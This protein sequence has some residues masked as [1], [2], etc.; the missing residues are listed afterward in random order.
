[1]D[2][3]FLNIKQYLLVFGLLALIVL[4]AG[5][6]GGGDDAEAQLS[7]ATYIKRA[8]RIC[9]ETKEKTQQGFVTYARQNYVPESGA[10]LNAKV[11]DFVVKVFTPTYEQQLDQLEALNGPS[12]DREKTTKILAAM[13]SALKTSQ[14]AP[15]KFVRGAPFFKEASV[16]ATAYGITACTG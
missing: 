4:S 11:S 14:Q 15:L 6:C 12:A 8:N 5:G 2:R 7:K 13:R 1:M 16:L 10:A 9:E 3:Y